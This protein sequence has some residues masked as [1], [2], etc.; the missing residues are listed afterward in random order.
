M[1]NTLSALRTGASLI[2][3]ATA[4]GCVVRTPPITSASNAISTKFESVK[5]VEVEEETANRASFQQALIGSLEARGVSQTSTASHV[6]DFALAKH[7]AQM[8]LRTGTVTGETFSNVVEPRKGHWLDQCKAER[9]RAT[10]ALYNAASGELE[11]RSSAQSTICAGD[12][13]AY[14]DIADVLVSEVLS[15]D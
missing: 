11:A 13:V 7:D 14:R 12:T 10:L 6:A 9:V 15:S 1:I 4:S 3:L 5:F 2:L 8:S